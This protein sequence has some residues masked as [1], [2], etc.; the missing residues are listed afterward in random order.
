VESSSKHRSVAASAD[1]AQSPTVVLVP[2]LTCDATFW[3]HQL[4]AL[5]PDLH[6]R[7]PRLHDDTSIDDMARSALAVADGPLQVV[8]HSMGG[9]VAMAMVRLAPER[10]VSL[11]L[12][13][14]G[15]HPVGPEEPTRRQV[16]LD[17]AQ[18]GGMADLA[19]DWVPKMVHPDRLGDDPVDRALLEEITAMVTSY[20]V[21]QYRGQIEALLN[22]VDERPTLRRITCP[23]LVACGSHD[24]WSPVDQ[25]RELAAA[26]PQA[27]LEVIDG[28]G[29]MVAMERPDLTTALLADWLSG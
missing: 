20:S 4:A 15:A 6:C 3:R 27:R 26:I 17:L 7:V 14:T 29:H 2:G 21:T 8:G 1:S 22:R 23:T 11:A 9:R 13:D 16:R 18:R 19:A 25:H 12:L 24:S 28:A 5:Q 10:I